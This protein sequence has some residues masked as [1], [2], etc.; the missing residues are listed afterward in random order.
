MAFGLRALRATSAVERVNVSLQC[1]SPALRVR[2]LL[3]QPGDLGQEL[4]ALS[5]GVGYGGEPVFVRLF[6]RRL[7]PRALA[8]HD[9]PDDVG[10]SR[11]HPGERVL[12]DAGAFELSHRLLQLL[13]ERGLCPLLQLDRLPDQAPALVPGHRLTVHGR[14]DNRPVSPPPSPRAVLVSASAAQAAV[15]FVNFGLPALGPEL[16]DQFGLSLAALGA[17][18]TASLFGS[19]LAFIGAGIAVD[20]F[21]RR[22]ST[23]AGTALGTI[24]LAA[25]ASA[26]TTAV[27]LLALA[28]SGVGTAVVPI[29]GA[30]ALFH[31]YQATNRA[32]ALG[33]RQMAVPLGGT[34]AAVAMPLL[35]RAG[36]V[37]LAFVVAAVG[38]A[39]TG[40]VFALLP[41]EA[42]KGSAAR[43]RRAFRS[44]LQ[45]PGMQ[46]L[47]V[48]AALYIVVLQAVLSYTVPA[49][50]A[51]GFSALVAAVS[52]F[53]LTATAMTARVVWGRVADRQ[54]GTRRVRTLVEVGLVAAVGALLFTVALHAGPVAIVCSAI[55]CG[56]GALGWNALVYVSAGERAHP[57]LA[58]RSVAV[59]AT[60]VFLVSALS[61][62]LLGA[63]AEEAS[64]DAFWVSAAV[65]A[66][67][68]ALVAARLPPASVR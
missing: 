9:C 51:A 43:P 29:A 50:R 7:L 14:K 61:T 32:W 11:S 40:L 27:L 56:F 22:A 68:G 47:L 48:T 33:V 54:E 24:G 36:G 21:G 20:R 59:A 28:V 23:L 26:D 49:V 5:L 38:V 42:R 6:L 8:R 52:Y 4:L 25:A 35:A 44:I 18:L 46:R 41:E 10:V 2:D 19:G 57:E 3:L 62:P 13:E 60:V 65:L 66:A 17:V 53:A 55:V 63:V 34:I 67:V 1:V 58:A 39:A 12:V 16:R 15:S 37:E 64:W 31:A 45:A 30:S